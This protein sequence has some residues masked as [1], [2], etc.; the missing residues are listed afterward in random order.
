MRTVP[1]MIVNNKVIDQAKAKDK[2]YTITDTQ[3]SGL[4]IEIRPNGK[5]F[6]IHRYTMDGKVNEF[7]IGAYPIVSLKEA[8]DIVLKNKVKVN[9]GINPREEKANKKNIRKKEVSNTFKSVA[10]KYF[11]EV[12]RPNTQQ[13]TWKKVIPYF[14]N[15]IYS[16]KKLGSKP[17]ADIEPLDLYEACKQISDRGA[18]ESAKRVLRMISNIYQWATFLGLV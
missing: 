2:K 13:S 17:I 16:H 10:E 11:Q 4:R 18:R 7:H 8:R 6:F 5:K 12:Y 3:V 9:Q 15:D 1:L 14:A